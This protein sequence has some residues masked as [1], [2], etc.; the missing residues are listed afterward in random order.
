MDPSVI[1]ASDNEI[2][3]L[4]FGAHSGSWTPRGFTAVPKTSL[5]SSTSLTDSTSLTG[6]DLD[7][8]LSSTLQYLATAYPTLDSYTGSW[9]SSEE[10]ADDLGL[11]ALDQVISATWLV[12]RADEDPE[13]WV[14]IL[15][16]ETNS[17]TEADLQS[18]TWVRLDDLACALTENTLVS[19]QSILIHQPGG[20]SDTS[21][22]VCL[23]NP[24][25]TL[26]T[27]PLDHTLD[28]FLYTEIPGVSSDLDLGDGLR[29]SNPHLDAPAGSETDPLASNDDLAIDT[30]L[31]VDS[32]TDSLLTSTLA[33]DFLDSSLDTDVD[34]NLSGLGGLGVPGCS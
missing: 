29:L 34:S 6:T 12:V 14:S 24:E 28:S 25:S 33:D 26:S 27:L 18:S 19:L 3:P 10:L 8:D 17:Q 7:S 9:T 1:T 21:V 15:D 13:A 4:T 22:Y 20:S 11:G 30:N 2:P 32:K 16:G 23:T 5:V 31:A